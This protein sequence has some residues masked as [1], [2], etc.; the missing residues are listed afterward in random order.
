M[1]K[2]L[3][4]IT[5]LVV[6]TALM[7]AAFVFTGCSCNAG[8]TDEP[9][10]KKVIADFTTA[11]G[12]G[13]TFESD[14]WENGEPFNV[15]WNSANV[16][17]E[18]NK[19][20][21]SVAEMTEENTTGI[22]EY[23]GGEVRT[24]HYYGYGDFKVRM[25][26]AKIPG[27]ASTFFTC[28]GP[29]DIWYNE[30]GSE[31]RKNPHDEIDIEFLGSD[32]T[33]VQF[34]YFADGVGGHE[35]MIDLGF[36][37]SEEFHEYGFRWTE[38][39]ITWFIDEKPVYKVSKA[40]IKEGE[41]WPSE[42][43]RVLMNYWV[44]TEKASAWMGEFKD[45]YS[46]KAEYEWASSTAT[47]QVDPITTK[48]EEKPEPIPEDI[49]WDATEV[50]PFASTDV[51]TVTKNDD[52]KKVS[53]EYTEAK[54]E[55][56][57]N[58][59]ASVVKSGRNYVG[60]TLTG[61]TDKPINARINVRGNN[62]DLAKKA[63]VSEGKATVADGALVTVP[64]NGSIDVAVYY[65]GKL[66]TLQLMID[67][68]NMAAEAINANKLEITNMKVGVKG[69][70]IEPEP[71]PDKNGGIKFGDK[72]VKFE[73]PAYTVETSEDN[74]SMSVKYADVNPWSTLIGNIE[75]VVGEN[76]S[77]N[78]K[79]KNNGKETAKIRIDIGCTGTGTP[80]A[81]GNNKFC[82]V[83]ATVTG[84]AESGNDYLYTGGDWIKVEAGATATVSIKFTTGVGANN[85]TFFIDSSWNDEVKRSGEVVFS[86]MSLSKS[87]AE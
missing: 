12:H 71:E 35:K 50:F 48:P 32:T 28:T 17:Y 34:N 24:S 15:R 74:T 55:S 77:F 70:V 9:L 86:D 39:D 64:A 30:D 60:M 46:G 10:T 84:A 78:F 65:E 21:L 37:A 13:E 62:K 23:Y 44:G 52:E 82:N 36:D 8:L 51:Y 42:P 85:I 45:D 61:K 59:E 58:I 75:N 19:L 43:G 29:Y 2:R 73:G 16:S 6:A 25:K 69:E 22:A 57:K 81:D 18:D 41:K 67:S 20:A 38:N 33:K 31:A 5:A 80:S 63:Y 66:D 11:D 53:V 7:G 68:T 14:G 49:T 79:I 26:P 54:K 72:L 47:P 87:T 27:T 56:W 1:K 4:A 40:D 76:D 3:F 83:S